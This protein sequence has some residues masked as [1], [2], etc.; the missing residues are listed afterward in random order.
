MPAATPLEAVEQADIVC[1]AT[2]ST[3]PVFPGVAVRPGTHVNGVGSYTPEM[4]EIDQ[5]LIRRASIFVDSRE[6]ALAEAG[7]LFAAVQAGSTHPEQ[8]TELGDAVLGR[9]LPRRS[10]EGI[11]FFKS[12][13][14]AVQDLAA[15]AA[16]VG[17]AQR[18]HLGRVVE[19]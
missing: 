18:S 17:E 16:A 9:A 13:G 7:E 5:D 2:D 10:P 3:T 8:W 1:A 19:L 4:R 6:A 14:L 15:A 12:V 11:T